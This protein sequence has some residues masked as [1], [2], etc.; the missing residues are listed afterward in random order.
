VT[1]PNAL[2]VF[3]VAAVLALLLAAAAV[4]PRREPAGPVSW[5]SSLTIRDPEPGFWRA[6]PDDAARPVRTY[7]AGRSSLAAMTRITV[8]PG[9]D[10][11][12]TNLWAS[13]VLVLESGALVLADAEGMVAQRR[14][15]ADSETEYAP[16]AAGAL[17]IRGDRIAYRSIATV[18]LGNAE[19]TAA[20][21]LML[22]EI[23]DLP[24]SPGILH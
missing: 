7:S 4:D 24:L 22:A 16:V 5:G 9:D 10:L 17:L 20:S 21:L 1:R 14:P 18:T 12:L 6:Q 8:P 19:A 2:I 13:G 11:M 23:A 3:G 15:E